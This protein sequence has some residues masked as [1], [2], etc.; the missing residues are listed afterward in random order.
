MK[1]TELEKLKIILENI[2]MKANMNLDILNETKILKFYK[3]SQNKKYSINFKAYARFPE[4]KL[5]KGKI[6]NCSLSKALSL[7]QSQRLFSNKT[8]SLNKISTILHYSFGF[9]KKS[10][11]FVANR[12]YPSAGSLYPL[13]AYLI[14]INIDQLPSGLYHYYPKSHSL[15]QLLNTGF[16]FDQFFNQ[17]WIKNATCLI[18]ITGVF[19]RNY[20]KYGQR[21][22]RYT[23]IEAGHVGQNI[24]L[25][26]ASC[27]VNCCAIGGFIDDRLNSYLNLNTTEEMALYVFALGN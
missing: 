6:I 10:S 19:K 11:Q 16:N 18:I 8:L 15:E 20:Q 22:L 5:P 26:A 24:S 12:Y 9:R 14:A 4:I 25:V 21:S 23:L 7:R 3:I 2:G 27:N 1:K 13:E 17:D